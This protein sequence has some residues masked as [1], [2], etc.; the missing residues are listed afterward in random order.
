MKMERLREW[1]DRSG[2]KHVHAHMVPPPVM[3]L[4]YP[5]VPVTESLAGPGVPPRG[6]RNRCNPFQSLR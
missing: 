5:G 1:E 4:P 3:P 2:R 6:L